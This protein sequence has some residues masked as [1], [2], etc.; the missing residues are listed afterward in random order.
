MKILLLVTLIFNIIYVDFPSIKF[1]KKE[2]NFNKIKKNSEVLVKFN[3][4][5]TSQKLPLIIY[6]VGTT[7][8][9]T[10]TTFPKMIKPQETKPIIVK[11]NSKGFKGIISKDII[12]ISN[13]ASE[14]DKLT[15]KGEVL[16]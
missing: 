16:N 9:C 11:F 3:V 8:G 2:H 6:S 14:Y 7:C 5:N 4:T 13:T 1:D 12:V 10:T 15:I